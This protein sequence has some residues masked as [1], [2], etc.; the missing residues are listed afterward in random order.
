[1]GNDVD[2]PNIGRAAILMCSGARA[3]YLAASIRQ[4]N[5]KDYSYN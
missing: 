3:T 5:V 2:E 4:I 1:M